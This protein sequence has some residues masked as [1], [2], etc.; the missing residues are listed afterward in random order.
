MEGTSRCQLVGECRP[1]LGNLDRGVTV[2]P[3]PRHKQQPRILGTKDR[4]RCLQWLHPQFKQGLQ[5]GEAPLHNNLL[6]T[7]GTTN[8]T[9]LMFHYHLAARLSGQ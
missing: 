6:Q 9:A 1:Q 3:Q 2:D 5:A 8:Q 4:M 7:H